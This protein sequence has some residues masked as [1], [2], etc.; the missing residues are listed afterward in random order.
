MAPTTDTRGRAVELRRTQQRAQPPLHPLPR[1]GL[2]FLSPRDDTPPCRHHPDKGEGGYAHHHP[3]QP[4][5][6]RRQALARGAHLLLDT[7]HTQRAPHR[8]IGRPLGHLPLPRKTHPH[9]PHATRLAHHLR[10]RRPL[11]LHSTGHDPARP[12]PLGHTKRGEHQLR[13]SRQHLPCRHARRIHQRP[14]GA[15]LQ[16]LTRSQPHGQEQRPDRARHRGLA[17]AQEPLSDGRG[18]P[19]THERLLR[20]ANQQRPTPRR[21]GDQLLRAGLRCRDV[22]TPVAL[23]WRV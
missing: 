20:V 19:A 12:Q 7:P 3:R 6:L 5:R 13:P 16:P 22:G 11:H 23:P 10:P 2:L 17:I 4:P 9:T 14:V 8:H 1:T 15:P 18:H 21:H